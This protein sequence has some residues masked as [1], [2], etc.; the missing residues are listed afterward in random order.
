MF[1]TL[2]PLHQMVENGPD[3]L[4]EVAFVQT[5]GRELADARESCRRF[6]QYGEVNDLNQAWDAY[7][8]VFFLVLL[9]ITLACSILS[10]LVHQIFRKIHKSL[11]TITMLELQYVSPKLLAV[12]DLELAVPGKDDM[13]K[14]FQN[15][16]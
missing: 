9:R 11:N 5:F 16:N 12:H 8:L 14:C 4:R 1:A 13:E 10:W 6:K 2:E 3:T 15:S 7:Y